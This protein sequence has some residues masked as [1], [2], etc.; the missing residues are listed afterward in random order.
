MNLESSTTSILPL[1]AI[2][3][4]VFPFLCGLLFLFQPHRKKYTIY[5]DFDLTK[6]SGSV[7]RSLNV[8][9]V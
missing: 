8:M 7:A 4:L 3:C 2:F 1:R 5:N 9:R 6:R